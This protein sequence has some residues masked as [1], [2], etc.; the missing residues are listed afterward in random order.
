MV[1]FS[2][3]AQVYYKYEDFVFRGYILVSRL[4]K[5]GYSSWKLHTIFRKFDGRHTGLVHKFDNFVS[6]I[7]KDWFTNCD[8]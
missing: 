1:D 8:I 2:R 5:Q 6:H 3:Y 7:L 4:L